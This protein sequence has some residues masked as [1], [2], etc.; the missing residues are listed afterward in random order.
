MACRH[1]ECKADRLGFAAC[2][3]DRQSWAF[4]ESQVEGRE[5][6]NDA[7]IHHQPF[8]ESVSEEHDIRPDDN[9]YHRGD[10]KHG[11]QLS[12]HFIG[13]RKIQTEI[14]SF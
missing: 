11:S 14:L 4:E 2:A 10:V 7:N 1:G 8:P 6:Q 3:I 12:R 5:Y 13:S 9:G